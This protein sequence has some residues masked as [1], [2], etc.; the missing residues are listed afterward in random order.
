MKTKT[1]T[2]RL[3]SYLAAAIVASAAVGAQQIARDTRTQAAPTGTSVIS[4]TIVTDEASPQ[5]VR[6]AQVSVTAADMTVIKNVI[7]DEAG[8]F[9]VPNLPANRYTLAATKA[10]FVRVAF[11]AKRHDRPGT[12]ITLADGQQMTDITLRMTRGGVITGNIVDENGAPAAGVQVRVLQYRL[13][14]GERVLMPTVGGNPLGEMTDDRGVY[15]IYGLPPGEFVVTATPRV[16]DTGEIRAMTESEIRNALQALQQ[17]AVPGAGAAGNQPGAPP[18]DPSANRRD[19]VT[20]AYAPVFYPGTTS[21]S[22]AA[23]VAL[24]PGEE[25]TGVDFA[26]Q[27]V[28]TARIEGSVVTPPGISPQSVQLN[29]VA[30]GQA[31]APGIISFNFLSRVTPGPDGKFTYSGVAP[32][33]YTL[34]ARAT[35]PP[36]DGAPART[37]AAVAGQSFSFSTSSGETIIGGGGGGAPFWAMA[38]VSVDGS[39]VSNVVLNLQ[40]GMTLSGKIEFKGGNALPPTDLTRVRLNLTPAPSQLTTTVVMGLPGATVDATGKFTFSGVTP[41][42]YRISGIV[43]LAPGSG[44]GQGWTLKSAVVK[45]R[46]VLDFPL[47]IGPNE[48]IGD[49]LLTFTDVTQTVSGTLQDASGRPAPDYTIVVFAA[50]NHFWTA[51]SRRIRTARPGTDGKFTVMNLPAGEYRIAAVVD[52]APNEASDPTFLE[53]LVGASY[54]FTLAEGEKKVQD[55]RITGGL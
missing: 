17:P 6:R 53:Q 51:Q 45:G 19:D 47:D 32:G 14:Q 43:P 24:A 7:T 22:A 37:G 46:D 36:P 20:V 54:Q 44:P 11:G 18:A 29:L 35:A 30:V 39:P 21:A 27:L 49:A 33:S 31:V 13:Q 16:G 28:R 55:L 3:G 41:G 2:A 4:G 50:E 5:P 42:R 40:P 12:P 48:E 9:S 23:Q 15:R 38:D 52:I 34:T 25:R 1:K 26:L 8:R 10:G